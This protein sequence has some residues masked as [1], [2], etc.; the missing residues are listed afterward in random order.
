MSF[1][2]QLKSQAQ[3]LQSRQSQE[4][5]HVDALIARTEEANRLLL[6]Y[7]QDLARQLDVIQPPGPTLTLDGRNAWP[8][9]KLVD[10]RVD[11][12]RK[13][14]RNREVFDYVAMGWRIVPQVGE[15]VPAAV[16]V[17]FPTDMK[18]VEDRLMM[19][20]VQFERREV[21]DAERNNVLREV[22]YEFLTHTRGSVM[23]T[24]EPEHGQVR[25]RLLNT[26]GFEVV[27]AV[28]PATRIDPALLDELARR[29]VGQPSTFA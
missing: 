27:Q 18:R 25:F 20:P 21:R 17:N 28:W 16:C 19:G 24:S 5:Q 6:S 3:A 14:L 23:A 4:D 26:S 12:R 1:L 10:F 13:M 7:L 15:P 29:I 22:R 11:A 9:M 2:N 8:A